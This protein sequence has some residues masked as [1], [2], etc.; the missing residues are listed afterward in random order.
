MRKTIDI[1]SLD[2]GS[3]DDWIASFDV[4]LCDCDGEKTFFIKFDS[5]EIFDIRRRFMAARPLI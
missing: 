5:I 1:D 2:Q 4:V 3:I